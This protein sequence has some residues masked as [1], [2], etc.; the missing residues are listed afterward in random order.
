MTEYTE[1]LMFIAGEW[2]RGT[3]TPQDVLD[4]ATG[5]VI[6]SL[7]GASAEDLDRALASSA[8]GFAVWRSMSPEAR[9]DIMLKAAALLRARADRIAPMITLEQGKPVAEARQEIIRAAGLLEW[10]ANEGRRAYGTIVPGDPGFLR[11]GLK[12]PVGPVAAFSPWNFPISSPCRKIGSALAAGCSIILKASEETP[13]SAVAVV[14]ALV[15]AGVPADA[16]NLVFGEPSAISSHLIASPVTRAVTFTGS[17]PVGKH[18]AGLAAQ[19]MKP[20]VMELGGHS[21][22][23]ICDDVDVEPIARA[24]VAAKF[25]NAGQICTCP[26]RFLVQEGVLGAFTEAFAAA[27]REFRVGSGFDEGVRM[28]P[29]ANP[30]RVAAMERLVEDARGH[31]AGLAAGGNR[32]G[33]RGNFFEPTVLANVPLQAAVMNEE[34]FGPIA[35]VTGFATLDEVIGIANSLPFGLCSYGFST[36][37]T[38]VDRLVREVE[39][40]IMSI[41]H[42]GTSTPDSPFGGVK[43]SGYGREGGYQSLDSFMI[44][45]FISQKF[46]G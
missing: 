24:A 29:L 2:T 10:D 34:P 1:P 11:F 32:I 14:E 8:R 12:L 17:V 28:G 4:P 7:P 41:N 5:E 18:L 30:R 21:P 20:A 22:V 38:R 6:A 46:L 37:Q 33:E 35:P 16:I 15:D 40:G 44:T 43:E 31:G 13:V 42:F 27:A 36:S 3:G 39:S 19:V 25:R 23:I 26:T 9:G 45:K